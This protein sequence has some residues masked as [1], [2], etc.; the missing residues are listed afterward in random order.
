MS[1][2]DLSK[3]QKKVNCPSF[4]IGTGK[5]SIKICNDRHFRE[6]TV[7][8]IE[9]GC[10]LVL[11]PS[12]GSYTPVRL[13]GDSKEFGIWAVF[14]HPSGCQFIDGGK[15]V[16]EQKA[17]KGKGSYALHMVEFRKPNILT[18]VKKIKDK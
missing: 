4:D 5:I 14:V 11:S 7:Y 17:I 10:E 1:L 3:E 8:M 2:M 16:F 9:N 6:T 15:V 18:E 13:K 12:Y